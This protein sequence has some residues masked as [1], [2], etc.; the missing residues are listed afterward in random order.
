MRVIK[1]PP[2][3]PQRTSHW[4]LLSWAALLLVVSQCFPAVPNSSKVS[5]ATGFIATN[6]LGLFQ[7]ERG[8]RIEL[9]AAEPLVA[10]PVAIAFDE[11]GRLYVAETPGAEEP[12][13]VARRSGRIHLL[14]D[15]DEQG[16][17]RTS[18][19]L[20]ENISWPSAL[21][22][23]AGGLFVAST[24]DVLFI[25]DTTGD[26]VADV[27]RTVFAGFG[28]SNAVSS[29]ALLN[30]FNWGPNNR[31][32]GATAWLGGIITSSN[33]PGQPLLLQRNDFSFDPRTFGAFAETGPGASGLAFDNSGRKFVCDPA[34]PLRMAMYDVRYYWRN[35]T[36]ARA[37]GLLDVASPATT[38]FAL[39]PESSQTGPRSAAVKEEGAAGNAPGRIAGGPAVAEWM[40]NAHG[41]VIY[42]GN[43][44]PVG[45]AENAFVCDPDLHVVHR[46]ALTESGLGMTA[47]RP[48]NERSSEFLVSRDAAFRPVQAVNAPDGTLYIVDLQDARDHGRIYRVV[49]E[50]FTHPKPPQLGTAKTYDLVAALSH[51]NGWHRDTAARLL[52]QRQDPA[53]VPLLATMLTN[54]PLPVARMGALSA[55]TAFGALTEGHVLRALNDTNAL[56]RQQGLIASETLLAKSFVPTAIG[57]QFGKL[58]TD[59]SAR[60]RYQLAFS[61]GI[62]RHP[63]RPLLL[64]RILATDPT[65]P[66]LQT[67]V[68]SSVDEGAGALFRFLGG[69]PFFRND[70]AGVQLLQRVATMIGTKGR[71]DEV[72]QALEYCSRPS[73]EPLLAYKL[74][75]A[76]GE[77]LHRTRSSLGL[78]DIQSALTLVYNLALA[79]AVDVT[80]VEP[81]RLEAIRMIGVSPYT[82]NDTSDWL[83]LIANPQGLA[84]VRLAAVDTLTRYDDPRV[85]PALL[86]RWT[87]FTPLMRRTAV[88]ALLQ[89]SSRVAGVMTALERGLISPVD[90]PGVA[91]NLLRTYRDPVI[92][93][94]AVKLF[95]P[96]PIHRPQVLEQFRPALRLQGTPAN[97]RT[98]FAGRCSGCH[99]VGG[100]ASEALGP[101]LIVA[102]TLSR[103]K[104][105][106]AIVEPHADISP[107]FA[108]SVIETEESENLVGIK[109]DENPL[110]ITLRQANG[111][112]VWPRSNVRSDETQFWSMMPEGLEQGLSVQDMADLLE[113]LVTGAK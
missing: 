99:Q 58:A 48:A 87:G 96:V 1:R 50:K 15:P 37:P 24:P 18:I 51:P 29:S 52:F 30:N 106:S 56:V 97:G 31:I 83:L 3:L 68:L 2:G 19:L 17:Y 12:G 85:L 75:Y 88:M 78:V 98:I 54:S 7:V 94:H 21:A 53:A 22:C 45:Y 32:Y 67:A 43:A 13:G 27:R 25:K 91:V 77:G 71:L 95:G 42:R 73:L 44:Y 61:A 39:P 40:T 110:S 35:P 34:H 60:V 81:L 103:E 65:N 23:Y 89:K 14:E 8:F 5:H 69:E 104:L 80:V 111:S 84:S 9:V 59:S 62:A 16:Q 47:A 6:A 112:S 36:F 72:G 41:V 100:G 82:Y 26:G 20:A 109:T 49:P 101:D 38:V 4:L 57:L 63:D 74:V 102:R 70:P 79:Q 93:E 11:N 66:W 64:G 90:V 33:A 10:A 86:D 92:R 107:E 55:L 108:T 113:Y 46:M 105:L 76:L 28:G